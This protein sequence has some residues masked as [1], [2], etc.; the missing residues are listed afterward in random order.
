MKNVKLFR[1]CD[2]CKKPRRLNQ[3]AKT[4][5]STSATTCKICEQN[6]FNAAMDAMNEYY[7]EEAER[8]AKNQKE[9]FDILKETLCD[10]FIKDIYECVEECDGGYD[11]KIVDNPCG[12]FQEEGW[13]FI[14]HIYV[15]QSCGVCGDDYYGEVYIPLPENKYLQFSYQC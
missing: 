5:W 7:T 12:D 15:D 9:I 11:F 3:F 6:Q 13:D 10:D 1:K 4:I 14:K 2:T 8:H